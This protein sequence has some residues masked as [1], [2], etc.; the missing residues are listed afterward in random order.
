M[1]KFN[2]E[3]YL[4]PTPQQ[5][6]STIEAE[7]KAM[8]AYRPLVYV[9]SPYS[10]DTLKNTENARRYSRFAFEQGRIPIAPHLLFTQFLDDHNPIEREMGMHF[11]NVLM[12]LCREV[13]VFGD[14]ISPGMDAE[15]RRARWK[16]YRL[17]FFTNDLEEVER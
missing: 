8:K 7:K 11:G 3:H 2:D 13:W 10:G 6:L 12:S 5:A 14:I 16:N 17:K 9:C 1:N 4:D 15:I